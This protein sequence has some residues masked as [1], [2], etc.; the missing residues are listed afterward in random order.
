MGEAISQIIGIMIGAFIGTI[1]IG[2]I[3]MFFKKIR[4]SQ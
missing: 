1:G 4:K 3:K 2:L